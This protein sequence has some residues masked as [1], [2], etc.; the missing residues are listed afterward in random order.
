MCGDEKTASAESV[1]QAAQSRP[2][3]R[4]ASLEDLLRI[5]EVERACT[6]AGHWAES[7]YQA[8][9]QQPN[10]LT[11]VAEQAGKVLGFLVA[12]I[13]TEEW[14][15]ENIAVDP[16]AQRSGI[17]RAL[18]AALINHARQRNASEIRQEIRQSNFAAQRLG[19]SV[20][21]VQQGRR[22]NYYH[23]PPEDALLFKYLVPCK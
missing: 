8:A 11:L 5:L 19:Q 15:L 14:E 1:M 23:D 20:G 22:K 17:G 12:S 10:R 2:L 3:I 9:I 16:A 13:A 7:D 18:L 6:T 4:E 21:F